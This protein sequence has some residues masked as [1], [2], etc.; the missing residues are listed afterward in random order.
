MNLG[1]RVYSLRASRGMSQGELADRLGVSR[2]AVSKWENNSAV[3]DLDK[4]LKMSELFFVSLD[5][6][7]KGTA[8]EEAVEQNIK[9][10]GPYA[11]LRTS[12]PTRKI[13]GFIF[14]GMAFFVGL[15]LFM[16]S[17]FF[18]GLLCATVLVIFGL[19]C[20]FSE[21]HAGLKCLW[22]FFL[23][24]LA[25]TSYATGI[26][27]LQVRQTFSWTAEMNYGRLAIAWV[28]FIFHLFIIAFTGVR[29]GKVSSNKPGNEKRSLIFSFASV[30]IVFAAFTG[31]DYLL[32][33]L[34]LEMTADGVYH[35]APAIA[36]SVVSVAQQY[37]LAVALT[38][39]FVSIIRYKK[40]LKEEKQNKKSS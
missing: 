3:P 25:F 40:C 38:A 39:V 10:D 4:L 35:G 22:L 28:L 34:Y 32:M 12:L 19:I 26:S 13:F 33:K 15:A 20:L 17:A 29:L 8:T 14:F 16:M 36:M 24:E 31:I 5:E 11:Q 21:R 18:A 6:L 7:V 37:L 23:L 27:A 30:G 1:E 2:Q 9:N